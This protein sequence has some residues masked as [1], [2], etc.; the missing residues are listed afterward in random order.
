[1]RPRLKANASARPTTFESTI[2]V[3]HVAQVRS[4]DR[5]GYSPQEIGGHLRTLD[6]RE[7]LALDDVEH[8][9]PH[10]PRNLP[11]SESTVTGGERAGD[12]GR[13]R[14]KP[15]LEQLFGSFKGSGGLLVLAFHRFEQGALSGCYRGGDWRITRG[16]LEGCMKGR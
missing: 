10:L 11:E 9:S 8:V 3:L 16:E 7:D 2:P 5:E 13:G 4:R 15:Y 6:D 14:G 1:M 12:M